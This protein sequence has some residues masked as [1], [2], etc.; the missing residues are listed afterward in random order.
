MDNVTI[1][2]NTVSIS[3]WWGIPVP[4]LLVAISS[5]YRDR[6]VLSA[7][8][9]DVPL[10]QEIVPGRHGPKAHTGDTHIPP[11]MLWYPILQPIYDPLNGTWDVFLWVLNGTFRGLHY[12]QHRVQKTS[13]GL[14]MVLG[15]SLRNWLLATQFTYRVSCS[16]PKVWKR[17]RMTKKIHF[18]NKTPRPEWPL[19]KFNA[20]C[21]K[22][23]EQEDFHPTMWRPEVASFSV[24]N[25]CWW[26]TCGK[27]HEKQ[28]SPQISKA[29]SK[30]P[31]GRTPVFPCWDNPTRASRSGQP[32]S[33]NPTNK[34]VLV[35]R[36]WELMTFSRPPLAVR[37][38]LTK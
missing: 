35:P 30:S 36:H 24:T 26:N 22:G 2:F 21:Q 13:S 5:R 1:V 16:A 19:P 15:I 4:F 11:K 34:K 28:Q 14:K 12:E 7:Q 17:I 6:Q 10:R 27:K 23:M 32:P 18:L 31:M 8:W 29:R 20:P 33:Q 37:G 25:G 9:R 38:C 3:S